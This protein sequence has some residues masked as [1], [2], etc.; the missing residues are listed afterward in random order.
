MVLEFL[1][2]PIAR[3]RQNN[4]NA[5]AD[6]FLK[7]ASGIMIACLTILGIVLDDSDVKKNILWLCNH[8]AFSADLFLIP[9]VRSY[10]V[11]MASIIQSDLDFKYFCIAIVLYFWPFVYD[12]TT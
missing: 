4:L 1:K 5:S 10:V 8:D 6:W 2:Q 12:L 11:S 9:S 3:F 7:G